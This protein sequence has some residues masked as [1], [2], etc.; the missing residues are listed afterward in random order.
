MVIHHKTPNNFYRL[1]PPVKAQHN[2]KA[3][4][5]RLLDSAGT[6]VA[7]NLTKELAE[8][9]MQ[10]V[11]YCAPAI[12]FT[13][14]FVEWEDI[15]E[16]QEDAALEDV[17][18]RNVMYNQALDFMVELGLIEPPPKFVDALPIWRKQMMD[19]FY[20]KVHELSY[21]SEED[22]FMDIYKRTVG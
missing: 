4:N 2:L 16:Y 3:K 15:V 7:D 8:T 9:F 12:E 11:N 10:A 19:E 17:V 18:H 5:W 20:Q 6:V 14:F 13:K 22:T 1:K 21:S